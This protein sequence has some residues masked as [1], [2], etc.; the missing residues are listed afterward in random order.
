MPPS[1]PRLFLNRARAVV[2]SKLAAFA[3]ALGV[4]AAIAAAPAVAFADEAGA[5][6]AETAEASEVSV[7]A[8]D[9]VALDLE[10]AAEPEV[11]DEVE[12]EEDTDTD[13]GLVEVEEIEVV[14]DDLDTN[15]ALVVE[16]TTTLE[17]PVETS[18]AD[19]ADARVDDDPGTLLYINAFTGDMKPKEFL[20]GMLAPPGTNII[21]VPY[22]N[23]WYDGVSNEHAET[24]V[25]NLT[26]ALADNQGTV[27]APTK[28]VGHSAGAQFIY[29]WVR[30]VGPTSPQDPDTVVFYSV[31]N[32]EQKYTGASY[33]YPTESPPMYPGG[34]AYGDGWGL[35]VSGI[36]WTIHTV[37]NE[38]DG[39]ADAPNDPNNEEVVKKVGGK[40]VHWSHSIFSYTKSASGPHSGAAYNQQN[41]DNAY[42]FNDT[43]QGT[44]VWYY[45]IPIDP[46]P[47]AKNLVWLSFMR[48]EVEEEARPTLNQAY[49]DRPVDLGKNVLPDPDEPEGPGNEPPAP[50]TQ[51]DPVEPWNFFTWLFKLLGW[52]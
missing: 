52:G 11:D 9:T 4:G 41:L 12:V 38:Y 18:T 30:E 1:L 37:A 47:R 21:N 8:V 22:P 51:E 25:A 3:F 46:M 13:T 45:W 32:P 39:W 44:N 33:R 28:V 23:Q 49:D 17:A 16:V 26:Q 27:S 10:D 35:P 14:D 2:K 50:P 20:D 6:S 42:S 34:G 19:A 40:A 43:A 15:D 24:A 31:G 29:K 7:D 36:P 48:Q 5:D